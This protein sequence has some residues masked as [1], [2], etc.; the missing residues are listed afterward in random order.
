MEEKPEEDNISV[1]NY[2]YD[3]SLKSYEWIFDRCNAMDNRT[4]KLLAS[5]V[6]ITLGVIA[7][8]AQKQQ[9]NYFNSWYF[10]VALLFFLIAIIF[11]LISELKGSLKLLSPN[12]LFEKALYREEY[13]FKYITIKNT[14]SNYLHNLRLINRKGIFTTI[15]VFLF[16]GEIIFLVLWIILPPFAVYPVC[17]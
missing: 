9:V 16:L 4:D 5:I 6:G 7:I 15:S 11:G 14:S 13:N 10:M 12:K 8:I 1:V 17:F 2:V 3:I